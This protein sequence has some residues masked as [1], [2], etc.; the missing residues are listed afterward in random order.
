VLGIAG[1]VGGTTSMIGAGWIVG[2]GIGVI[3]ETP[4]GVTFGV[5][6]F[7]SIAG[8]VDLSGVGIFFG[9]VVITSPPGTVA[10]GSVVEGAQAPLAQLVVAQPVSQQPEL[11]PW[12]PPNMPRKREKKPCPPHVSQVL[13][14]LQLVVQLGAQLVVVPQQPLVCQLQLWPLVVQVLQ[15]VSQPQPWLN[16]R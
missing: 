7:L 4:G 2:I 11:W 8:G 12:P 13:Q 6:P 1:A 15:P 3:D 9:G 5:V 16:R 10:G 14:V